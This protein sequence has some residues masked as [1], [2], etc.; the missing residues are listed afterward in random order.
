MDDGGSSE[1]DEAVKRFGEQGEALAAATEGRRSRR[2]GRRSILSA[3]FRLLQVDGRQYVCGG[4]CHRTVYTED[5]YDRRR[6]E[7]YSICHF[8]KAP[9]KLYRLLAATHFLP[10]VHIDE[11]YLLSKSRASTPTQA[12]TRTFSLHD[13]SSLHLRHF[14]SNPLL[15]KTP[16][17]FL[18]PQEC[19]SSPS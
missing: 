1:A 4:S 9:S 15:V 12:S 7:I 13:E 18:K 8:R 2:G 17:L 16:P 10:V 5:V 6:G 11:F 19:P 14:Q 3:L